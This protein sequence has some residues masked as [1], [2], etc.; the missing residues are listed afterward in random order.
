[1]IYLLF[2]LFFVYFLFFLKF[3]ITILL[4]LKHHFFYM[5]LSEILNSFLKFIFELP[6]KS[7]NLNMTNYHIFSSIL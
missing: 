2:E 5:F 1:M 7:L 6:Q 4:N 3:H